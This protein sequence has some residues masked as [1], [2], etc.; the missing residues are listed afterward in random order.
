MKQKNK[1]RGGGGGENDIRFSLG[2]GKATQL[3]LT[4]I[5]KL[6]IQKRIL[7]LFIYIQDFIRRVGRSRNFPTQL[8]FHSP[9]YTML[10]FCD[11]MS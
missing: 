2:S 11:L 5:V 1:E 7:Y 4:K 10:Q 3:N 8:N 6:Y 9:D